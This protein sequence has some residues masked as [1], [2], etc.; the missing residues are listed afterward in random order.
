MNCGRWGLKAIRRL[1]L[2]LCLDATAFVPRILVGML[3][4][5]CLLDVP[6]MSDVKSG[7]ANIV[8]PDGTF[9]FL[10]TLKEHAGCNGSRKHRGARPGHCY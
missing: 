1:L 10:A 7:P 9:F 8:E 2:H 3:P 6:K 4:D 5:G